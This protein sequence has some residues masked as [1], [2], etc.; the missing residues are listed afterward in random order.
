M[1]DVAAWLQEARRR[2]DDPHSELRAAA[3]AARR[4]GVAGGALWMALALGELR[5]TAPAGGAAFHRLGLAKYG[6]A[7]AAAAVAGGGTALATSTIAFA[8]PVAVIAFYLVESRMVFAFP[9]ALDG[10]RRPLR[11]SHRLVAR[12]APALVATAV[13]LRIAAEMLTGGCRGR[14]FLRSWCVGC[15]AVLLWYEH[16]RA[17]AAVR[18]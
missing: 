2:F 17:A 16:A 8:A 9:L 5:G 7:T 15:L 14:G 3:G 18:A 11:D 12:T 1:P 13:V 6:I 4:R 10:S